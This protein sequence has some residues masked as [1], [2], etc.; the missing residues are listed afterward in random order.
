MPTELQ[1]VLF[2]Q[3]RPSVTKR[4]KKISLKK[5]YQKKLQEHL[6]KQRAKRIKQISNQIKL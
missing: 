5:R 4:Y 1:D 6:F 2:Y 3:L